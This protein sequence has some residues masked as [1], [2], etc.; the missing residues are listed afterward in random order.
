[1]A[2]PQGPDTTLDPLFRI[3][4]GVSDYAYVESSVTDLPYFAS[5][6]QLGKDGVT[7]VGGLGSLSDVEK[8]GLEVSPA[9]GFQVVSSS[10]HEQTSCCI[11]GAWR[12]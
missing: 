5:R 10:R 12:L 7:E 11:Q 9:R 4:S 8:A 6:V 1:M 2:G 3:I